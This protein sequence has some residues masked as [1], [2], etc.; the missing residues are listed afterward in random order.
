MGPDIV[1]E[2]LLKFSREVLKD[3]K[4]QIYY[5]AGIEIENKKIKIKIKI[6]LN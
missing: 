6:K 3:K 2:N 1:Y 4:F 5:C